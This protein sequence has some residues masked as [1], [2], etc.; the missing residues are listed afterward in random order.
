[1]RDEINYQGLI[2]HL[3][4]RQHLLNCDIR[5][6]LDFV[7]NHN[8]WDHPNFLP[9]KNWGFPRLHNQMSAIC[10]GAWNP[11]TLMPSRIFGKP[12]TV[13][14]YNFTFPNRYRAEGEGRFWRICGFS[15][16]GWAVS[17]RVV[18]TYAR[19]TPAR[20]ADQWV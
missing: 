17:F 16:L 7:D 15:R 20:S 3:N 13:T 9:G 1:M 8:Y 12:F 10:A 5:E 14:E 6:E 18:V 19:D 2:T 11:R 4:H